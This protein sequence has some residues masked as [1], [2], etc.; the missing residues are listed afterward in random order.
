MLKT[1]TNYMEI[2]EEEKEGDRTSTVGYYSWN[3]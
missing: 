2:E 3:R 1:T